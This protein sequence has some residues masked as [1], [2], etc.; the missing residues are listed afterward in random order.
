MKTKSTLSLLLGGVLFSQGT[1]ATPGTH[2]TCFFFDKDLQPGCNSTFWP[3]T[4]D[5][6][7]DTPLDKL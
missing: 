5:L 6:D 1:I 2:G 3:L 7:I 4:L